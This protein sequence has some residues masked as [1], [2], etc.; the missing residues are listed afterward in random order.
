MKKIIVKK[1]VVLVT[2][3]AFLFVWSITLAEEKNAGEG[4]FEQGAKGIKMEAAKVTVP[5][6]FSVEAAIII[7]GNYDVNGPAT[8]TALSA[9]GGD[10]AACYNNDECKSGVC[11]G[12]SCCTAQGDPCNEYSHCCGHPS[13]GC[14]N[15]TCP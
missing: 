5:E 11:E 15:G 12:G 3:V 2:L 6:G 10:G 4:K 14:T 1:S 8:N 13:Q 9:K 7:A